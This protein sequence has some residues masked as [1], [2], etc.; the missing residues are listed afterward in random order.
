M[1]S[2]ADIMLQ[3]LIQKRSRKMNLGERVLNALHK[4]CRA[5][6]ERVTCHLHV[7][8]NVTSHCGSWGAV[9]PCVAVW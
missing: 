6:L 3:R 4:Y 7:E 1:C 9:S 8:L 5:L 2:M